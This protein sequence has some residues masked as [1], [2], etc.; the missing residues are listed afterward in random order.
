VVAVL[1]VADL[2]GVVAAVVAGG[3]F[4]ACWCFVDVGRELRRAMK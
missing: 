3:M 1:V 4:V 2:R